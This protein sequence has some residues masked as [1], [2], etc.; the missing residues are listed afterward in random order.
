MNQETEPTNGKALELPEYEPKRRSPDDLPA[1]LGGHIYENYNGEIDVEFPS[2][3]TDGRWEFTNQGYAGRVQLPDGWTMLLEPKVSL[4]TLFGMM[5][6]AYD[7]KSVRFLEGVYDADS[8][9]GFFDRVANI[10][11]QNVIRRSNEGFHKEY[12]EREERSTFIRGKIDVHRTVQKPWSP[13][14][15]QQVRELTADIEDNQILL[16][17]LRDVLSSGLHRENTQRNVRH[18]Y[19][20][21]EPVASLREYTAS[22]CTGRE[23]RRLNSDYEFMHALC[24]LILDNSGPTRNLGR[25][26]MIPFIV[27]MPTLYERFVARWLDAH[28][29]SGY[30]IEAQK[31][32]RL[33]DAAALSFDIDLVLWKDGEV[34]AVADTKYKDARKPS[35]DDIAQVVAYAE[36]METDEAIL[37][38]PA[39][40]DVDVEFQVGNIRVRD[41]QFRLDGAI[42]QMGDDF[43][44]DWLAVV[45]P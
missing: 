35:T 42:D 44:A 43:M 13:D 2:P 38:Y 15:H 22:D 18:A 12:I 7:L 10:L 32:V 5:E 25:H 29:P 26:Q 23:Y 21:L 37:I 39:D 20:T 14:V 33:D 8:I 1:R 24:Y 3:K 27:E 41:L 19:R 31:T 6:Y 9:E 28:L 34:V 4:V 16:W 45:G 40:L 36:R 11:A 30:R 17:T